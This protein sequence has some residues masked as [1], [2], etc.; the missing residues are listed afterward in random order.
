MDELKRF[1]NLI[2]EMSFFD[3]VFKWFKIR[4]LSFN[5]FSEFQFLEKKI[6]DQEKKI[7]DLE[8]TLGENYRVIETMNESNEKNTVELKI[9]RAQNTQLSNENSGFKSLNEKRVEEHGKAI[10]Q[11]NQAT[12]SVENREQKI[13]QEKESREKEMVDKM[14]RQWQDHEKNTEEEIERLCS[15]LRINYIKTP[16]LDK[17][18]DNTIEIAGEFIIFDAKSPKTDD[19]NNFP[20][21]IKSQAKTLNKYTDQEKV[22]KDIFLVVPS[23]TLEYISQLRMT[24]SGFNVFVIAKDSIELV[25]VSLKKIEDIDL[26]GKLD[27]RDRENL[28][29]VVSNFAYFIGRNGRINLEIGEY[30]VNLI[31]QMRTLVPKDFHEEIKNKIAGQTFNIAYDKPGKV[32]NT[33][34]LKKEIEDQKNKANRLDITPLNPSIKKELLSPKKD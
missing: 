4:S 23:N 7:N 32:E 9:L 8:K 24:M 3:R 1:F 17:K 26:A 14:K 31:E 27:P 11:L 2:K 21:Y 28:I 29:S 20:D 33:S 19:L 25:L 15:R 34:S 12:K 6:I 10:G 30:S 18:P 22:K 16:P 5:A 13:L